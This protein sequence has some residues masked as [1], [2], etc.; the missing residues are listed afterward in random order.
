MEE[1]GSGVGAVAA[2]GGVGVGAV[3]VAA[4]VSAV[5]TSAA[6]SGATGGLTLSTAGSVTGSFSGGGVGSEGCGGA[7]G[8]SEESGEAASI[9]MKV[10]GKAEATELDWG[11]EK[12]GFGFDSGGL[13]K[14]PDAGPLDKSAAVES[15]A[16]F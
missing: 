13:N 8:S 5:A 10:V 6:G 4:V 14:L 16:G 11:T 7:F 2:K 3:T 15:S 9:L 12:A 1:G